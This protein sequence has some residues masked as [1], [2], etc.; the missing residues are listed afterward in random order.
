MEEAIQNFLSNYGAIAVFGL[1]MLSGIGLA[2]GEE[3][4]VIPAGVLIAQGHLEFW[5][6][7]LCA[8]AGIVLSDSLWFSICRHYGTPL[9]HRR[10]FKRM[11]HPRRLLQ[12]KHQLDRLGAGVI[13]MA[14]FIPSSRVTAMTI[15]GM[16]QLRFWKFALATFACVLLT[17]PLQLGLGY[18]IGA[19][20]EQQVSVIDLI[21]RIVALVLV[22][23]AVTASMT[24][25]SKYWSGKRRPPRAKAAWLRRFRKHHP[26]G[27]SNGG[28]TKNAAAV[29]SN[30]Q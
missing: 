7:A 15:A 21:M 14:R 10:W 24:W 26:N 2:L 20:M 28:R 29:S 19:G 4:V 6:V 30:D 25:M 8:Y 3:M 9:I 11:V 13:V 1:L 18:L 16:F 5:P 17:V 12:T 22:I 27:N 23:V